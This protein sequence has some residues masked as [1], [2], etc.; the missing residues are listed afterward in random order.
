[1]PD[2]GTALDHLSATSLSINYLVSLIN[3]VKHLRTAGVI[4]GDICERNVCVSRSAVQLIDFGD[5][6][7]GYQNDVVAVGK[8]LQWCTI[9]FSFTD[10]QK[11]TISKAAT[12]LIEKEDIDAALTIL[13]RLRD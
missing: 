1:M 6:A 5:I 9:E 8:L 13:N 2:A 4:H 10:A 12:E 7:P 11:N 3:A